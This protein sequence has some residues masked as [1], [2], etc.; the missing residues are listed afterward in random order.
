MGRGY[1]IVGSHRKK[2]YMFL[3]PFVS[4]HLS[5]SGQS[6]MLPAWLDNNNGTMTEKKKAADDTWTNFIVVGR[7]S[8]MFNKYH[9]CLLFFL[10]KGLDQFYVVTVLFQFSPLFTGKFAK[11]NICY[12]T[13][14][15]TKHPHLPCTE[16]SNH[17]VWIPFHSQLWHLNKTGLV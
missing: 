9:P 13:F 17:E 3:P 10:K 1:F 4:Q 12:L 15:S 16:N 2:I 6:F 7:G 14:I 5:L 8:S 11:A